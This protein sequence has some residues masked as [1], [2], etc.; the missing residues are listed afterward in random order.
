MNMLY[1][2]YTSV[3]NMIR[4][5]RKGEMPTFLFI[6]EVNYRVISS[7]WQV[8]CFLKCQKFKNTLL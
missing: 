6:R 3:E 4:N 1:I 7:F 2:S 8:G 5:L